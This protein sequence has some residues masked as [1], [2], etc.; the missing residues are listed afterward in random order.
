MREVLRVSS[1]SNSLAEIS[2]TFTA[3]KSRTKGRESVF[4]WN[5]LINFLNIFLNIV[6]SYMGCFWI[7]FDKTIP[8]NNE[9]QRLTNYARLQIYLYFWVTQ[10]KREI[11]LGHTALLV[12]GNNS[13]HLDNNG[14]ICFV[15]SYLNYF[16]CSVAAQWS[17]NW[18]RIC[19]VLYISIY[20]EKSQEVSELGKKKEPVPKDQLSFLYNF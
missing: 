12:D 7:N 9:R 16:Y 17:I 6:I 8:Y 15:E 11:V 3:M 4:F 1:A 20:W 18:S 14:R 5:K 13:A 2:Y 10:K 19:Y